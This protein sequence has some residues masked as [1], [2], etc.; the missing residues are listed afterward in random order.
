MT[1][2]NKFTVVSIPACGATTAA[3]T[4]THARLVT[5]GPCRKLACAAQTDDDVAAG[6]CP[7]CGSATYCD[8][9]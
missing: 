3:R 8:C 7:D 5:C 2:F 6:Y 4:T 9:N 1:H